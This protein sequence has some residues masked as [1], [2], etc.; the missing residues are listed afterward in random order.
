MEEASP[1]TSNQGLSGLNEESILRDSLG[2]YRPDRKKGFYQCK[3]VNR[4][5]KWKCFMNQSRGLSAGWGCSQ[6]HSTVRLHLPWF[7]T[8]PDLSLGMGSHFCKDYE[9]Q[10]RHIRKALKPSATWQYLF[11][12]LP[13]SFCIIRPGPFP[14]PEGTLSQEN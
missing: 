5:S 8:C 2:L 11:T 13:P 7:K 14:T 12:S 9:C 4:R 6:G 3:E 10:V 1:R